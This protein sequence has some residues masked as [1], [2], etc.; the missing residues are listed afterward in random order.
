VNS[1]PHRPDWVQTVSLPSERSGTI[2][3][4]LAQ[5]RATLVWLANLAALELHTPLALAGATDRPTTLVF[6]LDPGAPATI[7]ECC[8]VGLV[9]QGMFANLGLRSFAKTSG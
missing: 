7:V 2:D 9:L 1:V 4:T 6:D 3:H 8:H 5:D